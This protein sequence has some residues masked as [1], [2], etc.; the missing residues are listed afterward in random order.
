MLVELVKTREGSLE[1]E[2]VGRKGQDQRVCA[3]W[4]EK[5]WCSHQL[6][7]ICLH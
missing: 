3:Q 7:L 6:E 1:N 4:Y 2:E 5:G